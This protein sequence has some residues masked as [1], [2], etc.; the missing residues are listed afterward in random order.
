ML[1]LIGL[2]HQRAYDRYRQEVL[3]VPDLFALLDQIKRGQATLTKIQ[4]V[5]L[6]YGGS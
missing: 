2:N 3:M 5:L 4:L 1:S 6:C